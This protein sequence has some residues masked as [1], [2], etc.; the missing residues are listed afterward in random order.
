MSDGIRIRLSSIVI[1]TLLLASPCVRT[2]NPPGAPEGLPSCDQ[3][4]QN[5]SGSCHWRLA[6]Y[7]LH[8]FESALPECLGMKG[9]SLSN[10]PPISRVLLAIKELDIAIANPTGISQ[11]LVAL[12]MEKGAAYINLA[13][14]YVGDRDMH[15]A[16][17]A[18]RDAARVYHS[19][20]LGQGGSPER[21]ELVSRVASGLIRAGVPLESIDLMQ[22]LPPSYPDRLY[23]TA[24]ALFSL[25]NRSEAAKFYELWI[26]SGCQS[27]I[28]MITDDEYGKRW[29]L[30]LSKTPGTQTKCEQLP[31]ELRS[32]LETLRSQFQHPDNIPAHSYPAILFPEHAGS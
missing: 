5:A 14:L 3:S 16:A 29:A 2:Q 6:L 11:D 27:G 21:Y 9:T 28:S 1:A 17:E 22:S 31:M 12:R 18:F 15:A 26:A 20:S 4:C 25:S 24:E 13:H 19:I 23:L 7:L 10:M 30:L 8:G 32:R